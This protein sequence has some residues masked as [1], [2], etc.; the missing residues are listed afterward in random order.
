MTAHT[1]SCRCG[2]LTATATGEPV[3]VSVCHCLD[4]QRRSGSAFA[5]QVR[6]PA[7]QVTI[8]GNSTEYAHAGGGGNI[9]R[10]HFC[11]TCGDSVYFTNDTIPETI[12]IALGTLANPFAFTPNFSVWENRKHDWI[13]ITGDGIEHD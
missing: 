13:E 11:P 7:E 1:A 6:F 8:A 3:R 2:Q 4:C 12:A 9:A 10:F 5:A